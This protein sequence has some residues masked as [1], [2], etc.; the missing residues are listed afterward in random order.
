MKHGVTA[1][2]ARDGESGEKEYLLIR[3]NR[4]NGKHTG[5]Y[6]PPS[7]WIE[8]GEKEEDA[9]VRELMEELKLTIRPLKKIA[10]IQGDLPE[11]ILHF[12]E[13]ELVG[14]DVEMDTGELN[15]VGWFT[16][17]QMRDIPIYPAT[18][19]LFREYLKEKW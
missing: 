18:A 16:A 13:C 6:Y 19:K 15:D 9:I 17:K 11:L 14:G 4:D 2:I 3:A 1:I 8:E 10:D 7:G 5:K 12:W